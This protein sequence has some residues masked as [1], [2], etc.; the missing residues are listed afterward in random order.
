MKTE[1]KHGKS[2]RPTSENDKTSKSPARSSKFVRLYL[3][4]WLKSNRKNYNEKQQN[5]FFP[6]K[7][8]WTS[9]RVVI[10]HPLVP[11]AIGVS[12]QNPDT[13]HYR[14]GARQV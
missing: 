7:Q 5:I 2:K 10:E 9:R 8:H 13:L 1:E 12:K 6:L 4:K 14:A 3:Q 11:I